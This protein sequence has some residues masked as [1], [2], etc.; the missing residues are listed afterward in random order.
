MLMIKLLI[1]MKVF[2]PFLLTIVIIL[3]TMLYRLLIMLVN[4]KLFE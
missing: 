2:T 1:H 3:L 4:S